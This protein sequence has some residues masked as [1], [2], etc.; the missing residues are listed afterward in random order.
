MS[1]TISTGPVIHDEP[2]HFAHPKRAMTFIVLTIT[3][4]VAGGYG[5]RAMERDRPR[6]PDP[7]GMPQHMESP[8]QP[9]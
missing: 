5:L 3:A 8:A 1:G 7:P 4:I 9:P 2:A 6:P